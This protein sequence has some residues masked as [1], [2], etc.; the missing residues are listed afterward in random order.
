MSKISYTGEEEADFIED[1]PRHEVI[2]ELTD[3]DE[4]KAAQELLEE[5][6]DE[7][8]KDTSSAKS[9][10]DPDPQE[11]KDEEDKKQGED[12]SDDAGD[13]TQN[14][15]ESDL[16]KKP[17]NQEFTLTDELI[18][19]QPEDVKGLLSKYKGKGKSELAKAAANAIAMKNPYLKDNE[20]AINAVAKKIEAQS[21]DEII[22]TLIET[23][24]E[25]GKSPEPQIEDEEELP[26][27][28]EMPE[29]PESDPKVKAILDKELVKRLKKLYPDMPEDMDSVE[30]KEWERELQDEGLLKA[31]KY[32][33]DF[34]NIQ[35][36]VKG[37]FQKVLFAQTNLTNLYNESPSEILQLLT[38]ENLPKLKQLNDNFREINNKSL[39]NEV[40]LIK[41]ELGK[42]GITEKDL[43]VD[44]SLTKDK[45]GSLF[46]ETL[47]ELMF[48]GDEVD[49][50]VVG[51]LGKVPLLKKGNL[52]EK[53]I[54]VNNPKILTAIAQSK[55]QKD[56]IERE[57][58]KADALNQFDGMKQS[59]IKQP[60]VKDVT[61][62]T[63]QDMLKKIMADI[64]ARY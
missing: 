50:R 62:V 9:E 26:V 7:T 31:K 8:G 23:Q 6:Y 12:T 19:K 34:E 10:P 43:G 15:E 16:D 35:E 36:A 29:L 4:V 22:N 24:K 47:N 38:E 28:I 18:A 55:A 63:D 39:Q 33:A 61:K 25:T 51:R 54:R 44:L 30:Y 41:A 59:G 11:K 52:M 37:E 46:N 2:K 58:L 17:D 56:K 57:R 53:F 49:S 1:D 14:Q 21:E 27:N 3:P 13:K 45:N 20:E 48:N 40:E 42:Y 32:L 60:E 64:E 5:K